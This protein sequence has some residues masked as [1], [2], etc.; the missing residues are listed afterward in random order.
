MSASSAPRRVPRTWRRRGRGPQTTGARWWGLWGRGARGGG[1]TWTRG[2][3]LLLF[4]NSRFEK[5]HRAFLLHG[6]SVSGFLV[7][8]NEVWDFMG[9]REQNLAWVE[10]E[11]LFP[12]TTTRFGKHGKS[13]M[14][15]PSFQKKHA[16]TIAILYSLEQLNSAP[17]RND[18]EKGAFSI[19]KGDVSRSS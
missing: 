2:R 13:D 7:S 11:E 14:A 6:G 18:S 19:L 4:R 3:F 17:E 9:Q 1:G 10:Q 5:A 16:N 8:G 15:G 12:T